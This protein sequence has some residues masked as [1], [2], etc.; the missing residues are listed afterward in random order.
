MADQCRVL[1][2]ITV[3]LG[4]VITSRPFGVLIDSRSR[5]SLT[6]FQIV[7][8]TVVILSLISG[9]FFGRW[10]GRVAEPLEFSIP[11]D[12]LALMGISLGSTVLTTAVKSANDNRRPH[13]VAASMDV[14]TGMK[15]RGAT[16]A[17]EVADE[18]KPKFS[19]VFLLEEGSYA[20]KVVDIA[21]Y[22]QFIITL[23]LVAAYVGLAI[24]AVGA[25]PDAVTQLP[26]L[27]STFLILLGAS[28]GAYIAGKIPEQ[29]GH[30]VLCV[31]DRNDTVQRARGLASGKVD[32]PLDTPTSATRPSG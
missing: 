16:A 10:A 31:A 28:H 24:Q 1:L 21:K 25:A 7:L 14:A 23:V 17:G 20:D 12:V 6:H 15:P 4:V 30:P 22:Q 2:G 32:L 18:W 8:W 29:A 26:T 27:G 3:A 11:L 13:S 19:Q 5:Y 9:V